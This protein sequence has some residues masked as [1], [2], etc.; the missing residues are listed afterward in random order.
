MDRALEPGQTIIFTKRESRKDLP[1][2]GVIIW[3]R[4]SKEGHK[5]GVMFR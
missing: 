4:E 5:A 1:E 2:K 3:T